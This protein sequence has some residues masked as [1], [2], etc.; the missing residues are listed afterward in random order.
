M[1]AG[2]G[3]A[4]DPAGG[5]AAPLSRGARLE[6]IADQA[7]PPPGADAR[8][9]RRVAFRMA[10]GALG[11]PIDRPAIAFVPRWRQGAALVDPHRRLYEVTPDG[12][13]RMIAADAVGTLAVDAERARLAYVTER[14]FLGALH[15]NDG[16]RDA[17]WAEGLASAGARE[18]A[19]AADAMGSRGVFEARAASRSGASEGGVREL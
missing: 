18:R 12:A 15:V 4:P 19:G 11:P 16:Q 8:P 14:G 10:D 13:R 1:V 6:V 5:T 3:C 2:L 9:V 7:P 17:I